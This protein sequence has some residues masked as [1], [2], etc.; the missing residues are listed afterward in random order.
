MGY[1]AVG[2][3]QVCFAAVLF[4]SLPLWGKNK[5]VNLN[6]P[7]EREPRSRS[8]RPAGIFAIAGVKQILAAFFCYCAI[9]A[10]VG[11]WGSSYLVTARNISPNT[12][13]QWIS[14]YYIGIT[15]GRF[16]SGFLTLKLNNR[17]MVRLGQGVIACGIVMLILP[18]ET[19]LLPALFTIGL[20]CAP[21][22]P[23]LIHE[24]PASFGAENSQTIIGLQ[25]ASAY[26]GTMFIPPLFGRM[27][28]YT[29]FGIFSLFIGLVLVIM[30][31]MV[32]IMKA[33]VDNS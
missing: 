12:A 30:V 8:V 11:L 9:E 14:L 13:A 31:I 24:T 29:G 10:T 19:L 32:E 21:I 27:V 18:F 4:V 1:R 33:R 25:M 26:M 22:Y 2:I 23:S 20:G 5:T 6:N 28:S 17:Q 7:E 3:I 16:I 15:F